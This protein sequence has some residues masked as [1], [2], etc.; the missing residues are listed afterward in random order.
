MPT[1]VSTEPAVVKF[2]TN[3]PI[4][5]PGQTQYPYT[6]SAA[7]AIPVHGH[8]AVAL[9]CTYA[10]CNPSFPATKYT[11]ARI[12]TVAT[13]FIASDRVILYSPPHPECIWGEGITHQHTP[14]ASRFGPSPRPKTP[15]DSAINFYF[16]KLSD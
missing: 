10:S 15:H 3:A 16:T 4:R 12:A 5:I 7:I 8:T 9:A 11:A 13:F 6:S 1:D 2:T 14:Q